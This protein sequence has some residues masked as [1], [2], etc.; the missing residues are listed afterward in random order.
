MTRLN[1]QVGSL[2]VVNVS[3][4]SPVEE[5]LS[6]PVAL[7]TSE[8]STPQIGF[9]VQEAHL[10]TFSTRLYK[11]T[12]I[13]VV[14]GAGKFTSAGTLYWRM[15]KNGSSVRTGNASVAANTFYTVNAFFLDVKPGDV[16]ELALWSSVGDSNWD[17]RALWINFTRPFLFDPKNNTRLIADLV[18]VTTTSPNTLPTLT[19]GNPSKQLSNYPVQIYDAEGATLTAITTG[20]T[21]TGKWR[22]MHSTYGIYRYFYHG[23]ASRADD[24]Y[25][26]T[27]AS[28]RPYHWAN[29]VCTQ[30]RG[31]MLNLA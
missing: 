30:I 28:Y 9:T 10:P 3:Y 5:L 18:L 4:A 1:P 11:V 12:F 2:K 23:D 6:T 29:Y 24:A 8:P 17:Y 7:P 14:Y 19:L 21:W 25:V 16:L 31:R 13:G 20:G 27:H 22:T 26:N 15:K